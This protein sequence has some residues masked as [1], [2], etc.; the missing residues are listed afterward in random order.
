MNH[1]IHGVT[2]A[3][4]ETF[5]LPEPIVEIGAYQVEGQEHIANLRSLFPGKQYLGLDMRSG[6][7]VDCV[8]NVEALPQ[9]TGS[10]GTVLALNAFEHVKCFWRGLDEVHRVLRPDGV[11][12]LSTPFHFRIHQFPHDYWRFTP[13][14]YEALLD[15]YPS[16]IIGWHGAKNRPANVWAIACREARPEITPAE[17]ARYRELMTRHAKEPETTW[18]RRLR[19]QF[20]SWL[21]GRGPFANY[22]DR[23]CWDSVC[24]NSMAN[25]AAIPKAA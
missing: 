16:K 3:L 25:L 7:G 10:V 9:P 11:L 15:R 1:F 18:T 12:I 23:N 5:A 8:A 2:R 13:A 24:L 22:L 14:A 17:Y 21:C 4:T 6:P 19:Y 20:A